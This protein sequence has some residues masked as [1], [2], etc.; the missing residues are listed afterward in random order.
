M[1]LLR[2]KDQAVRETA[3]SCSANGIP[4]LRVGSWKFIPAPE[5]QLY[6]LSADL[7]ESTNLAQEMPER[8]KDMH[9]TLE[10]LITQGRS[11]PGPRQKNDVTVRRHGKPSP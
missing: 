7:A 4:G 1:P 10:T 8:V 5:P 6:D 11:T 9:G 2:G 3:I